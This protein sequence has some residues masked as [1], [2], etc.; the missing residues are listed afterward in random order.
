MS[1]NYSEL[2]KVLNLAL[3]Q[4]ESGKG[5]ERHANNEPFTEQLIFII[6]KLVK[7][8]QLGQAIKKIVESE[9]LPKEMAKKELLGAINYISAHYIHIENGITEEELVKAFRC[10]PDNADTSGNVNHDMNYN[11][12]GIKE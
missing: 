6:E 2:Q 8:F 3:E 10:Y 12:T 5:K 9:R 11:K 4:A 1:E 7:S